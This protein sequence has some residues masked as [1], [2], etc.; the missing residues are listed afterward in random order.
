MKDGKGEYNC[1][2]QMKLKINYCVIIL[3]DPVPRVWQKKILKYD[4]SAHN[5]ILKA[6]LMY[7][8]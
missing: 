5:M 4:V 7:E 3:I 6:K 1:L 8:F 2:Y